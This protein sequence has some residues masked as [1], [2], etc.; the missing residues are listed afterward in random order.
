MNEL[1]NSIMTQEHRRL[2]SMVLK[3]ERIQSLHMPMTRKFAN[4]DITGI[5]VRF[6]YNSENGQYRV[7]GILGVVIE[8]RRFVGFIVNQVL[9]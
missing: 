4:S 2:L 1:G 6:S 9:K 3:K 7:Q 8:E 5:H